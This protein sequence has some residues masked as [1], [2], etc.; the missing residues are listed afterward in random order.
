MVLMLLL[1]HAFMILQSSMHGRVDIERNP[2]IYKLCQKSLTLSNVN[3]Y[4]YNQLE[5]LAIFLKQGSPSIPTFKKHPKTSY[6]R[7]SITLQML[8]LLRV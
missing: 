4:P 2:L 6:N 3:I 7:S 5:G 1:K 8:L